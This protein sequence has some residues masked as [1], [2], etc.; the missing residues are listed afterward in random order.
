MLK[1]E[2]IKGHEDMGWLKA[3]HL[4]QLHYSYIAAGSAVIIGQMDCPDSI[5]VY[6]TQNPF[7]N[8]VPRV[9][10]YDESSGLYQEIESSKKPE[11][12]V[13]E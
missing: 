4:P 11:E 3:T 1:Q 8:T 10:K 13:D 2:I 7:L 9:F 6:A 12:A 5:L